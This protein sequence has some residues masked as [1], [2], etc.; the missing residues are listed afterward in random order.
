LVTGGIGASIARKLAAEGASVA[1]ATSPPHC[2][3][4]LI[5]VPSPMLGVYAA[6]KSALVGF[7]KVARV[8]PVSQYMTGAIA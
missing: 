6:S 2:S 5:S 7:T 8:S 4:S 1:I 3:S